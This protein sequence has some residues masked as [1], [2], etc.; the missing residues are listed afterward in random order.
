[1]VELGERFPHSAS[2]A[3]QPLKVPRNDLGI[4]KVQAKDLRRCGRILD[5]ASGCDVTIGPT[6]E[7]GSAGG[8]A[9]QARRALALF[10]MRPFPAESGD[11]TVN[12]L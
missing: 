9:E 4:A 2:F 12:G 6:A 7:L 8:G 10:T 3:K 1:M 5:D 11:G